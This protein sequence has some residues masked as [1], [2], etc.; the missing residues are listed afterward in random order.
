[1][2]AE[3][4]Y[5]SER[6]PKLVLIQLTVCFAWMGKVII[7]IL[8]HMDYYSFSQPPSASA[9]IGLSLPLEN[10]QSLS[11]CFSMVS[12][13]SLVCVIHSFVTLQVTACLPSGIVSHM[14]KHVPWKNCSFLNMYFQIED[15][16]LS[17]S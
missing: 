3:Q 10:Q 4:R 11:A 1:M 14:N 2:L 17:I 6:D 9:S 5:Q 15:H 13:I 16:K 12:G 8:G 7:S